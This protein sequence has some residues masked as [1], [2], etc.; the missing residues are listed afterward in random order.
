VEDNMNMQE[1]MDDKRPLRIAAIAVAAVAVLVLAAYLFGN[2]LRADT[3]ASGANSA[4]ARG[5]ALAAQV[6]RRTDFHADQGNSAR[7]TV[8]AAALAAQAQRRADFHADQR[9]SAV[10]TRLAALS[11]LSK[12]QGAIYEYLKNSTAATTPALLAAPNSGNDEY[13][14][15]KPEGISPSGTSDSAADQS[16]WIKPEG[17]EPFAA[18]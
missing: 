7:A 13:P 18:N 6:Q 12:G 8:R 4:D 16:S 17:I 5:V 14:W 15:I 10:A 3:S 2:G 11:P 9:N 1:R